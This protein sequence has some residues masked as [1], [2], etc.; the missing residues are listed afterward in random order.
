LSTNLYLKSQDKSSK[1]GKPIIKEIL[2]SST[3]SI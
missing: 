2:T 1:T 3:A